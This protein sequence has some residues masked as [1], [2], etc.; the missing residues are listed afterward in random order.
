MSGLLRSS[1]DYPVIITHVRDADSY[2]GII[3]Y[4]FNEYGGNF[5]PD[6]TD[7]K[8]EFRQ[9]GYNANEITK[10]GGKSNRHVKVGYDHRDAFLKMLDVN[11][12]L[13][14]RKAKFHP[15][16]W[17]YAVIQSIWDDEY[18]KYGRIKSITHYGGVNTNEG[19]RD[20][21]GG[22]EF[23]DQKT[24]PPNFPIRPPQ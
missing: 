13:I 14:P 8:K 21:I 5:D 22:V 15:I 10:R 24:Y 4:G 19:M 2:L 1:Y 6:D 7:G 9:Y 16:P 20:V 3:D 23:Y 11:P 17:R 12:L 18:E